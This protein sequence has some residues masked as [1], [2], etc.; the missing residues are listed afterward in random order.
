VK[1]AKAATTVRKGMEDDL[2]ALFGKNLDAS[3]VPGLGGAMKAASAGDP[4]K[5]VK[6]L[7][8]VPDSMR[9]EVVASGMQTVF[10]NAATRGEINFTGY[11]KWYEGLLR[12]KQAYHAVMANLPGPARK[13]L[14]DLYRVSKGISDSLS[15]RTKTGL[16]GSIVKSLEEAPDTLAGRLYELAQHAG[17]GLGKAIAVDAVGGHGS[18]LAM[19][20]YSAVRG[21]GKSNTVKAVD[22]LIT[23]PEFE[24]LARTAGTRQQT[25]SVRAFAYSKPFNRFVRAIGNPRE[26]SNRER[27]V[28][29]AMQ[30]DNNLGAHDARH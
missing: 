9:Q 15:A 10:R 3:V 25:A 16:H 30:T 1:A 27:W 26:M 29:G 20:L 6:M 8:A 28:L 14:S 11:A 21:A 24:Q 7:S 5:L 13:Q 12:N 19:G 22:E 23:S 4:T 17:K 2:T 18:G